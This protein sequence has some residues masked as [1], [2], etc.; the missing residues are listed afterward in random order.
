MTIK[1]IGI[2]RTKNVLE[3]CG[4]DDSGEI[5]QRRRVRRDT[6][7]RAVGEN[8]ACL[9][10]DLILISFPE[11]SASRRSNVGMQIT[12]GDPTAPSATD[13]RHPKLSSR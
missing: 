11:N 6:L 5:P 8:P 1:T 3:L 13:H 12:P 10:G 9:I 4:L 2:D 7:R